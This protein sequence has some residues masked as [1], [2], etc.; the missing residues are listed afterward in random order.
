MPLVK[1]TVWSV[2]QILRYRAAGIVVGAI[3]L[4]AAAAKA[5]APAGFIGP[6]VWLEVPVRYYPAL[7]VAVVA[8]ECLLGL[9]LVL[10]SRSAK[11]AVVAAVVV[12]GYTGILFLMLADG[13]P[14]D[15]DCMG[16]LLQFKSEQHALGF[17]I[18]RNAAMLGLL[19]TIPLSRPPRP[20]SG[21]ICE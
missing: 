4:I 17:G 18:G 3:F 7:L 6:L 10:W 15:C 19:S 21:G 13:N 12:V 8:T 14:P 20:Q 5:T 1:R 16:K 11:V 9:S 2:P